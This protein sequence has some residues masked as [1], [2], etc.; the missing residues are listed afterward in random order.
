M[1]V[2]VTCGSLDSL[3]HRLNGGMGTFV[4]I[5]PGQDRHILQLNPPEILYTEPQTISRPS[6]T[7]CQHT[8]SNTYFRIFSQDVTDSAH[9]PC[10]SSRDE[11]KTPPSCGRIH[12]MT[13][14]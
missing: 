11:S 8:A 13:H 14:A 3:G 4:K 6:I 7:A 2:S 10:P 9:S 5:Y 1:K 12:Q